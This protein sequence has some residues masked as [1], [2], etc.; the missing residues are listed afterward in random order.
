[1]PPK[2]N[3]PK[4]PAPAAIR[5][6]SGKNAVSLGGKEPLFILGP[7]VIEGEKP[8]LR[9]ARTIKGPA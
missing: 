7:C 3:T 9:A 4:S 5:I 6:G 8:L 2:K 1:M